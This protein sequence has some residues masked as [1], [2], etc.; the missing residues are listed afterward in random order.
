M[1]KPVFLSAWS[2][3]RGMSLVELM[4]AMTLGLLLVAGAMRIFVSNT[5]AF[6]LQD[7]VSDMQGSSRLAIEIMMADLRR[8]GLDR[9]MSAESSEAPD[10]VAGANDSATSATVPGL[11]ADSD[12]I[13]IA[14]AAPEDM[15]DCEGHAAGKGAVIYNRYFIATDSNPDVPALFCAGGVGA[16]P[17]TTGVALLRGV[18]SFQVLYGLAEGNGSDAIKKGNGY[19]S[20]VRYVTAGEVGDEVLVTSIQ[21]AL[22]A[23]TEVGIQGVTAPAADITVL[24]T[25]VDQAALEAV[26]ISGAYPIHRLFAGTTAVRNQARGI[27]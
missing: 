24:D 19:T 17:T 16:A 11:L 8:A 3:Q 12:E 21:I 4:I 25:V 9:K 10:A 23:R 20:P 13:T 2:Q 26:K 18:E 7:R 14:Y 6:R 15:T 1:N 5:Q 22:L 27:L